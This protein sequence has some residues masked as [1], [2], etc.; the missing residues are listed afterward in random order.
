MNMRSRLVTAT[1]S[2]TSLPN[3]SKVALFERTPVGA[4]T[5]AE[6]VAET[7]VEAVAAV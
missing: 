3:V 2:V 7:A 1:L 5:E 4:V 6:V